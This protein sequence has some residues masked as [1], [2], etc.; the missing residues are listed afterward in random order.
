MSEIVEFHTK[1]QS[2]AC[3]WAYNE[4]GNA[5]IEFRLPNNRIADIICWKPDHNIQIIEVK[6]ALAP[7]IIQK[8][9]DKYRDYCDE[10]IVAAPANE[11]SQLLKDGHVLDMD[12]KMWDCGY[13]WLTDKGARYVPCQRPRFINSAVRRYLVTSLQNLVWG[14][15][16]PAQERR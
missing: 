2:Q 13:L 3:R 7:Y 12:N 4:H 11:V 6:T 14:N 5:A 10:L 16:E 15:N 1:L 9:L 8:T